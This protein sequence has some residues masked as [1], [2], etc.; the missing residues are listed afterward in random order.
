MKEKEKKKKMKD[1]IGLNF[2]VSDLFWRCKVNN[3]LR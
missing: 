3:T 2:K 1:R